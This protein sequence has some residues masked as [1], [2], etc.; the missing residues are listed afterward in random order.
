M[1][2]DSEL[3]HIASTIR[4]PRAAAVAGIVFSLLLAGAMILFRTSISV[5]STDPGQWLA[6]ESQRARLEVALAALPFAGIAFL[7]FIGVIR[8][9]LGDREDRF[10]ASIFLGSGL[11]FLAML[12][13]GGSVMAALV[14][15]AHDRPAD[16]NV[17]LFGHRLFTTIMNTYGLRTSAVF[18]I[19]TTTLAGRLS[20]IPLWLQIEGYLTSLALLLA[21]TSAPWVEILSRSGCSSS[22]SRSS[23][24]A[25][26]RSPYRRTVGEGPPPGARRRLAPG[27]TL[28]G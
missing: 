26:A 9:H 23:W 21:A 8:D 5:A 19:A 16:P 6:D 28:G 24:A 3:D 27:T 4:A 12:F 14:A 25:D 11:L 1:S 17:W 13:V 10:F 15:V 20:A 18:T 22:A 2:N 7:W